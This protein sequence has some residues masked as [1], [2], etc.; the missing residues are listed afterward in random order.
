MGILALGVGFATPLA[1]AGVVVHVAGHGIAKALGF[2]T[3][4]PLLRQDPASGETAPRGIA[5]ASVPTATAMT[6]SLISLAGLPPSPL[7]VSEAMILLGGMEAGLTGVSAV[8]AVLLSLGFLG[9]AHALIEGLLGEGEG[10]GRRP[11]SRSARAVALL[12]ATA[13]AALLALVV[14]AFA[15]PGS[16]IVEALLGSGA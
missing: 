13:A 7:F 1:I 15:L 10:R 2:Y 11:T 4:I 9:L 16:G 12:A 5:R 14:V 3:A 6:V 8:A